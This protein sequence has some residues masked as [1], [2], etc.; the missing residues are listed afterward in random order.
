MAEIPATFASIA[1]CA[2]N[3][4]DS[5]WYSLDRFV[6][7]VAM[8]N[9]GRSVPAVSVGGEPAFALPCNTS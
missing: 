5:I 7:A 4:V 2:I 1:D 3:Q 6:P 8:S 9:A